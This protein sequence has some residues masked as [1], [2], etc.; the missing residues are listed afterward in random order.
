MPGIWTSDHILSLAPDAGA[1]KAGQGLATPRKWETLGQTA[2][3]AWGTCQGSAAT[4]GRGGP[5]GQPAD[6]AWGPCR[7]SAAT[8]YQTQASLTG[9]AYRCSCPSRK[10]PCKHTLG[11]L[12]LLDRQPAAFAATAPPD[13]VTAWLAGR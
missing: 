9:A 2:D 3:V 5:R 7:G 8:P 13:W 12:L 4:P 1:A 11:L 6:G 10:L